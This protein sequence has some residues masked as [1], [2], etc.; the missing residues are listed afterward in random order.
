MPILIDM[1]AY[2]AQK[3]HRNR[4]TYYQ[5]SDALEKV[6]R[7]ITRT[8]ENEDR[9]NELLGIGGAGFYLGM[10]IEEIIKVFK[11][12]QEVFGIDRRQGR[13]LVHYVYS[14][15][16]EEVALLKGHLEVVD[17]WARQMSMMFYEEG[18]QS[19]YAIHSDPEKK[20]HV[21][22]VINS[23]SFINGMKYHT[24]LLEFESTSYAFECRIY[25]LIDILQEQG[26]I[27]YGNANLAIDYNGGTV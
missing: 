20:L 11:Y 7:Y 18:F 23:I 10:T 12:V 19:I 1:G 5:N 14:F 6:I 13:R 4:N 24:N 21:H 15:T 26:L 3:D 25:T 2:N 9:A 27:E 22:F 16:N 17:Y 8:R